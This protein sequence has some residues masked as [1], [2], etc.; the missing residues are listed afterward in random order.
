[1]TNILVRSCEPSC[2]LLIGLTMSANFP[3]LIHPWYSLGANKSSACLADRK[4]CLICY[5]S[6]LEIRQ[7]RAVLVASCYHRDVKV[8]L[9]DQECSIWFQ[10]DGPVHKR[11]RVPCL[12][13]L[14][15]TKWATQLAFLRNP[16][17]LIIQACTP[18][19]VH[20]FRGEV[21]QPGDTGVPSIALLPM[22]L[23]H[24]LETAA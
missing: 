14:S 11:Q 9:L 4:T 2:F 10:P 13:K 12:N 19:S 5:A 18:G 20:G 1:M 17:Y 8:V 24:A 22:F 23:L 15:G 3:I 16:T 6:L 7:E 21:S